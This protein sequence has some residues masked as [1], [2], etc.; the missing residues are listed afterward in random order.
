M[1]HNALFDALRV[2]GF[3]VPHVDLKFIG[4][5]S[6][7]YLDQVGLLQERHFPI[8]RGVK[9]RKILNP[10]LFNAGLKH[11]MGKWKLR[12]QHCGPHCGD[13]ELATNLRHADDLML[14][15]EPGR[16]PNAGMIK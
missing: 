11:A 16:Q 14:Y 3:Q 5:L 7:L 6:S 12:V 10:L 4:S 8:K 2:R 9:Q 15:A 13:D 1:Q